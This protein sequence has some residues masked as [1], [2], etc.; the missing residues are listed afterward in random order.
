MTVVQA[1]SYNVAAVSAPGVVV[2]IL[3]P[4][5]TLINGVPTNVVGLVG[6]AT[7]G[8]VNSPTRISTPQQYAQ[9]FG[10][11]QTTKYDMGTALYAA[12]QQGAN[13]FLCVR[14]TDG[15]DAAASVQVMDVT[16][17]T[18]VRGMTLTAFYT[19]TLGN[20]I[21]AIIATGSKNGSYKCTISMPNR[22]PEVFDNI[23][24]SGATLWQNM[25]NAINLGQ[26]GIRGPSQIVIASIGTSTALPNQTT[27]TLSG[28]ADGNTTI[29][30]STLIGDD[31]TTPRKGMYALRSTD[32]SIAALVDCDDSTTWTTQVSFGLFEGIYMIGVGPSGQSITSAISAKN[33]AGIDSYAFKLMLGD[34]CYWADPVNPST[35]LISP[36]GF[37]CGRLANL[38]PENSSLNK[39][40]FGIVATQKT[41]ANQ[42][43][44]TADIASLVSAGIDVISNPSPG[45]NYFATQ[46]GQNTSS[47]L[48]TNDDNYTRTTN[49]LA[50]TINSGIGSYIGRLQ[51]PSV[52]LEAKNTLQTSLQTLVDLNMIGDV[53]GGPAYKVTLDATNNPS[54]LV[55]LGIMQGLVQVVT[56]RTIRT[57][58]VNLENGDVTL[59]ETLPLAA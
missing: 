58:L 6:T 34:W 45:G 16:T 38:S 8:P 36:Q 9:Q 11:I 40:I 41:A 48:L 56:F 32:V 35:R 17:P 10:A 18:P 1:G 28:G 44:T 26:S 33:T 55:A 51:T 50:F 42:I 53:N 4:N 23:I 30:G 52:R 59:Q 20:K 49:F 27:Y 7:F 43:Y 12:T 47:N 21:Q 13:N 2:Q 22:A 15:T 57:F 14:V 3:P 19:G 25:V 24:G 31:S 5:Q 54:N 39:Q 37:I 46:T 29:T